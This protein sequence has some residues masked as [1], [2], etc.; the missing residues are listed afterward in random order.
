MPPAKEIID[1]S[2]ANFIS[3]RIS[4]ERRFLILDENSII[5]KALFEEKKGQILIIKYKLF[6]KRSYQFG[7]LVF[8]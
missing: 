1:G 7:L 6:L 3:L 2:A 5:V 8:Y 4:E